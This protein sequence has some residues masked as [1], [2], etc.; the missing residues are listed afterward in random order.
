MVIYLNL[1]HGHEILHISY[2]DGGKHE[3]EKKVLQYRHFNLKLKVQVMSKYGQ[4]KYIN[5]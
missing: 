4:G 3:S 2:F 1:S 5:S